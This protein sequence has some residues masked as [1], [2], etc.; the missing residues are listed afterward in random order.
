LLLHGV[1]HDDN[2]ANNGGIFVV[3]GSL[4]TIVALVQQQ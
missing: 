3:S 1:I 4:I 2:V